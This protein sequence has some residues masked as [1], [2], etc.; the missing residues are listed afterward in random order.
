MSTPR[1]QA[2]DW[3]DQAAA[4][5]D[6]AAQH[7]RVAAQHFRANLV[8]RAGAHAFADNGHCRRAGNLVARAADLHASHAIRQA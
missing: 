5:Y 6:L 7:L 8:P 3:L 2:A 4:E 1:Q